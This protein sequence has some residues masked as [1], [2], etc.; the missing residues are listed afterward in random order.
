MMDG[1]MDEFMSEFSQALRLRAL[2][3]PIFFLDCLQEV[4]SE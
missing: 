2:D 4:A 3:I 1:W